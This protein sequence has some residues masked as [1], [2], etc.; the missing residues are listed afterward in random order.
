MTLQENNFTKMSNNNNLI[1][2]GID[3]FN[4]KILTFKKI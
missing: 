1:I 4:H 3:F 2:Q